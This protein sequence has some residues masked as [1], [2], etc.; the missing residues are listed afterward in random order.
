MS[1]HIP[2]LLQKR[3]ILPTGRM[4]IRI[5]PGVQTE[6]LKASLE[7]CSELGICMYENTDKDQ[8][9]Y[10]IATRVHVDDFDLAIYDNSLTVNISGI[11][12]GFINEI[13]QDHEGVIWGDYSSIPKWQEMK[14]QQTH[15]LLAERLEIMYRSHPEL[16]QQHQEKQFDNLTWLC[17]RWLEILPLPTSEKQLLMNRPNCLDTCD[18]LMSMMLEPH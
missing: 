2:L 11:D 4:F 17:Q 6:T 13:R 15:K 10:H 7:D 14:T 9:F 8:R 18:Y 12:N 5:L 3:H 16:A 1:Q